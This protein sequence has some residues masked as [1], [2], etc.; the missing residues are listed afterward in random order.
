MGIATGEMPDAQAT[1]AE[2]HRY[3]IFKDFCDGEDRSRNFGVDYQRRSD[4]YRVDSIGK[5]TPEK[6]IIRRPVK[7]PQRSRH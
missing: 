3:D 6:E 1:L 4:R 5:R 2:M 7:R